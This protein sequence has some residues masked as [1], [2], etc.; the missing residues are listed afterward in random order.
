M[1]AI[2]DIHGIEILDSRGH[3]TVAATVVLQDGSSG[4]AA[5]PSGAST[6]S[7]EAVELRD[8]DMRRY[9]GRGVALAVSHVNGELRQAL[10]GMD[11]SDQGALDRH[12]IALDGSADKSRLG[13]NAILAVSLAAAKARAAQRK[14][15]LY[16]ALATG[17]VAPQLPVPMMNIINGGA[18]ADNN[19]DIQEFMILPVQAPSFKEALRQGAEVFHALRSLLKAQGRTTAVGD[20]GGFAPDLPSNAAALDMILAAI[21]TTGL[22][23]GK[24]IWL[25]L[26]VASSELLHEGRYELAGE[27]KAY[28][29]AEFVDYLAQL[30]AHYPILSIEDG[31]A[32]SDWEGWALLTRRLGQHVQLVGDD[33]FVTNTAILERGISDGAANAIL[34]KPNQIG[35]LSETLAAIDMAARAGFS[36]VVSHRSGET[37]DVTIADLAVATRARQ[38]KT[39]SLCRS[40]RVAKYNRLLAIEEELGSAG[41]YAGAG[42]FPVPVRP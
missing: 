14:Q 28:T 15:P 29:P 31:L 27:H 9:G 40:D 19:V 2:K 10:R 25:G 36:A 23:A 21:E 41:V 22:R 39:G 5:V 18:H 37:E 42:A 3:P 30:V 16:R 20:E 13:A 32:E 6:G 8:R 34:I 11:A 12:M 1:T 38:I 35:T 24:D 7:R 4:F 26:D 33:L 17:G